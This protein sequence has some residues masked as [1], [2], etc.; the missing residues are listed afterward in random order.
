MIGISES[1]GGGEGEGFCAFFRDSVCVRVC[2]KERDR[3]LP[4]KADMDAIITKPWKK[5][6]VW[7]N[8]L[9]TTCDSK[10]SPLSVLL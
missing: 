9:S 1:G 8:F 3:E 7:V 10:K 4:K 5:N 6:Y 2:L